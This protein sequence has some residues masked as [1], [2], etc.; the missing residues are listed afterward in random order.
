MYTVTIPIVRTEQGDKLFAKRF[1]L[2]NKCHNIIVSHAMHLLNWL[3]HN[4]EYQSW[5]S[6]YKA[7]LKSKNPSKEQGIRRK[8]LSALMSSKRVSIGLTSAGLEKYIQTWRRPYAR[9]LSSHQVQKETVRVW[10]GV[11]KV[12]FGNGKRL[13]FRRLSDCHTISTKDPKNGICLDLNT[14]SFRWIDKN[15][16]Y[17]CVDVAKKN[18]YFARALFNEKDGSPRQLSY[19]EIKREM[20]PNG[21]HYYIIA[22]VKEGTPPAT[23]NG[24]AAGTE[25]VGIDPGTSTMA[26]VGDSTANLTELAKGASRYEKPIKEL[27]RRMDKSKR[28]SNP[29]NFN[30]DGTIR[31]GK[32]L[33]WTFSKTYIRMK[34]RCQSLYR[35]RSAYIKTKHRELANKIIKFARDVSIEKMAYAALAR[36]SRKPAERQDKVSAVT[37]RNGRVRQVRKYKR[38]KRFGHSL[39]NRSPALFLAI[40]KK[41]IKSAGGSYFEINTRKFRASQYNHITNT[42]TPCGTNIRWKS[43]GGQTI[44]R[45]LYSAYLI[46]HTNTEG[47]SPDRSSCIANF[48]NFRRIHNICIAE[49]LSCGLSKPECFGF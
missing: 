3:E 5:L 28:I 25:V 23:K 36:R 15:T 22:Y 9:H 40:L 35:Q 45:D 46:K 14:M 10:K 34:M 2:M 38:K 43:I 17:K 31:R 12:L 41:K 19:C 30:E 21:W 13:H 4:A 26:F 11:E 6:E 37:A 32:K 18:T 42:C 27:L 1:A 16:V 24:K 29:E 48:W 47:T 39:Q 49:M 33:V 20:F 7:I 8:Q 44:Q